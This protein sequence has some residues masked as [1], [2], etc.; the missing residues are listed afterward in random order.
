MFVNIDIKAG[1][2]FF[3]PANDRLQV[4]A[5]NDNKKSAVNFFNGVINQFNDLI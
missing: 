5:D 1:K 2:M 4:H 3:E